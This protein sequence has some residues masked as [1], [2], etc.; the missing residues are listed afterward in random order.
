M[1]HMP[2]LNQS[3]P[4]RFEQRDS[5]RISNPV[6]QVEIDGNY[7]N[8]DNWSLNGLLIN[9]LLDGAALDK[10]VT[11]TFGPLNS[12]EVCKFSGRIVRIDPA[13]Q[14]TAIELDGSSK[15]VAAL[16][17]FWVLKFGTQ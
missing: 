6:L 16:L 10:T 3:V 14:Q 8:T 13:L 17:P 11:G 7:Y 4:N 15:E 5:Y 2:Q 9:G 12:T 1:L